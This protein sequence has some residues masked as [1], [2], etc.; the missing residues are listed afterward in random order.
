MNPNPA[1]AAELRTV[2][3][4]DQILTEFSGEPE[5]VV[6]NLWATW[7]VPCVAEMKDLRALSQELAG[8][9]VRFVGLSLDDAIPGDRDETRRKVERF[10]DR[11]N[12]RYPNI[13]WIGSPQ[14]IFRQFD[15]DGEIPVTLVFDGKG[16][17]IFRHQGVIDL[18]EFRAE[19]L[20]R[21]GQDH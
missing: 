8:K 2:D 15:L 16:R 17:E 11:E 21:I 9:R 13:Y 3:R 20:K 7:C 14:P 10:L 1:A 12:I 19:M 6:L 4:A 18:E 5:L